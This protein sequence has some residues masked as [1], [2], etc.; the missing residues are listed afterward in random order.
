MRFELKTTDLAGQS[1]TSYATEMS[2]M[3][4]NFPTFYWRRTLPRPDLSVQASFNALFGKY[5]LL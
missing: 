2:K 1:T 3:I 4:P 5:L